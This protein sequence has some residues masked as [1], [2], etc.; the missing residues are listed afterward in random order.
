M[1][2]DIRCTGCGKK[3][4]VIVDKCVGRMET[5]CPRCKAIQTWDLANLAPVDRRES[6][7]VQSAQG[8]RRP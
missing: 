8:E 5:M 1:R 6:A 7:R 3:L 4:A 2:I